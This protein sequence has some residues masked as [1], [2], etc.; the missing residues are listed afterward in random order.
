[1]AD[2]PD[3]GNGNEV[4]G[5]EGYELGVAVKD[6]HEAWSDKKAKER[7][8]REA[9]EKAEREASAARA[10]ADAKDLADRLKREQDKKQE[11]QNQ[12]ITQP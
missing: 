5:A 8:Q 9:T 2:N 3:V 4:T 10:V 6:A 1:M 7:E 12:T 11:S